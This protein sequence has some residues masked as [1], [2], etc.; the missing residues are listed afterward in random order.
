MATT[1][2]TFDL[3]AVTNLAE[4][5]YL[6]IGQ[7]KWKGSWML[8]F[9]DTYKWQDAGYLVKPEDCVFKGNIYF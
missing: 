7:A 4:T 9:S 1:D 8:F 5:T 6:I 2:C 3:Y